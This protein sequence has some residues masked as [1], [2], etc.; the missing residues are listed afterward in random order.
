MSDFVKKVVSSIA[1]I[2]LILSACSSET[3]V[4]STTVSSMVAIKPTEQ[5]AEPTVT[6]TASV[7]PSLMPSIVPKVSTNS[8]PLSSELSYFKGELSPINPYLIKLAMTDALNGWAESDGMVVR[9]TNGGKNWMK[10]T[11]KELKLYGINSGLM[12]QGYFFSGEHAWIA[13]PAMYTLSETEGSVWFTNNGGKDWTRSVLPLIEKWEQTSDYHINFPS[14]NQGFILL[15]DK[16]KSIYNSKDGGNHWFRI[17]EI[18]NQIQGVVSNISFRNEKEGWISTIPLEK[19]DTLYKTTD[20]GR[21][22]VPVHLP[23]PKEYVEDLTSLQPDVPVFF[24]K[25]KLEGVLSV[26][27]LTRTPDPITKDA[28]LLVY[29]THDGGLTWICMGKAPTITPARVHFFD[30]S[31][32]YV[33]NENKLY[34]TRDGGITWPQKSAKIIIPNVWQFISPK[35]G[36]ITEGNPKNPLYTTHDGGLTWKH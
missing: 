3:V 11:P 13:R 24:G 19:S 30:E 28:P 20:Y 14:L 7:T 26:Q 4:Q 10:A 6:P 31:N 27:F 9:T 15:S 21:T 25:D 1:F 29:S 2:I 12:I 32:G 22:W 16:Y 36:W 23:I 33:L 8:T 35:V 18:T 5:A 17:G 34:T